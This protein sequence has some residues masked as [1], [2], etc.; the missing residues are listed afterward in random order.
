[1]R[2]VRMATWLCT[3]RNQFSGPR[4]RDINEAIPT[5]R[6]AEFIFFPLPLSWLQPEATYLHRISLRERPTGFSAPRI[7][8]CCIYRKT[9]RQTKKK[10]KKKKKERNKDQPSMCLS[11]LRVY[12]ASRSSKRLVFVYIRE[13]ENPF[14]LVIYSTR[15]KEEERKHASA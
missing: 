14:D 8:T 6:V 1:M 13:D 3:K 2:S 9:R 10:K 4:F 7:L 11:A 12:R 15:N 5:R